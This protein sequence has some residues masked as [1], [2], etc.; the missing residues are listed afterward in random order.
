MI[1]LNREKT[2]FYPWCRNIGYSLPHH[3]VALITDDFSPFVPH[4]SQYA[5]QAL[6]AISSSRDWILNTVGLPSCP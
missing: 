1:I 5:E 3:E 4:R 6:A 2:S